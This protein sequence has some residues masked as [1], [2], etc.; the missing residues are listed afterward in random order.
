MG[1]VVLWMACG[2]SGTK[3]RI[4]KSKPF[5]VPIQGL[6][7]K[8]VD[9][10]EIERRNDLS[11]FLTQLGYPQYAMSAFLDQLDDKLAI[12]CITDLADMAEDD[13]HKEVG[14][15]SE[16][17]QKIGN[18][19]TREIMTRFLK[20]V[21]SPNGTVGGYVK[22]L[23]ALL[24]ADNTEVDDVADL[25]EDEAPALNM[26]VEDL[27]ILVDRA[28]IWEA[29]DTFEDVMLAAKLRDRREGKQTLFTNLT[30][31]KSTADELIRS[32]ARSLHDLAR[33][34]PN[35]IDTIPKDLLT[36]L[37]HEPAV[38][39]MRRNKQEL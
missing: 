26:S 23:D 35:K 36:Q 3:G 19:A 22:Y 4:K 13:E 10:A 27:R 25:D 21:P 38:V 33:M 1:C 37:L 11:N 28:E 17:A 34:D 24:D 5:G 16:E 20:T 7:R 32:G 6:E 14:I 9:S 15:S 39:A 18:A 8:V 31:I 2:A 12:D 29:R 30:L